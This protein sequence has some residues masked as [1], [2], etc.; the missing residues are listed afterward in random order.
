MKVTLTLDY[1]AP[2]RK[3]MI[4]PTL[5]QILAVVQNATGADAEVIIGGATTIIPQEPALKIEPKTEGT[6]HSAETDTPIDAKEEYVERAR[7]ML[8]DDEEEFHKIVW[9]NI[10]D[11]DKGDLVDIVVDSLTDNERLEIVAQ[12]LQCVAD[13]E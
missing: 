8:A 5:G 7:K 1:S 6:A 4:Q 13:E 3:G 10:S 9:E 12:T 11:N 2:M